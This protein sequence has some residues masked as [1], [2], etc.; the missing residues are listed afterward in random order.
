MEETTHARSSGRCKKQRSKRTYSKKGECYGESTK[1]T[2]VEVG[3]VN[4]RADVHVTFAH[5]I[6]VCLELVTD[7]YVDGISNITGNII[8]DITILHS[9]FPRWTCTPI[10]IQKWGPQMNYLQKKNYQFTFV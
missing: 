4:S 8:I 7:I 6:N 1:K 5:N 2:G 10:I 3:K 9:S